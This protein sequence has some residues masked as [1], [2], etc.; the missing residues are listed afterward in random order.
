MSNATSLPNGWVKMTE[1]VPPDGKYLVNALNPFFGGFTL[2]IDYA[3]LGDGIWYS[4]A[5]SREILVVAWKKIE[6]EF[7]PEMFP[8]L[9]D[10]LKPENPTTGQKV[11]IDKY[12]S[13]QF[14][15]DKYLGSVWKY[16]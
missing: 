16:H 9:A 14:G 6:E 1:Q 2:T 15:T 4:W 12:G 11:W 5:N 8:E 7:D 10:I 3:L 13:K